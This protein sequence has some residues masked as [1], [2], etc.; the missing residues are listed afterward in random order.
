MLLDVWI[1]WQKTHIKSSCIWQTA[2]NIGLQ[3]K[4]DMIW[5]VLK[6]QVFSCFC[7]HFSLILPSEFFL[8][9]FILLEEGEKSSKQKSGSLWHLAVN[10]WS[11]LTSR[12]S[13]KCKRFKK[14]D[15]SSKAAVDL[16]QTI[17]PCANV[18][19]WWQHHLIRFI[20]N[21]TRLY[22]ID[23]TTDRLIWIP[24]ILGNKVI[25]INILISLDCCWTSSLT[26]FAAFSL[27]YCMC[28]V[29][30]VYLLQLLCAFNYLPTS[31]CF[32]SYNDFD[33]CNV[34]LLTVKHK[35]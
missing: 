30:P 32:D 23:T 26:Y 3:K 8:Y 1:L 21:K 34:Q 16:A 31:W 4:K 13:L 7:P 29:K 15:T 35:S 2:V 24:Y 6:E 19:W 28:G 5:P 20:E 14:A 17:H 9:A 27:T 18:H 25:V 10:G 11:C 22:F 12:P 33:S